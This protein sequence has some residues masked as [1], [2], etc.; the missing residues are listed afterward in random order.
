LVQVNV[1][2]ASVVV[3]L[4]LGWRKQIE[5][6]ASTLP[7]HLRIR[8]SSILTWQVAIGLLGLAVLLVVPVVALV[9]SPANP[10]I[11]PEFGEIGSWLALISAIGA[12]AWFLR[13]FAP[14]RLVHLLGCFGLGVGILAACYVSP[15]DYQESWLTYHVLTAS[16]VLCG[17]A[18]V[19][20]GC[21]W[22]VNGDQGS[23]IEG[24]NANVLP[25]S[26]LHPRSS[27]IIFW[28][29]FICL[30]VLGLGLG[31]AIGDPTKLYWSSGPVLAVSLLLG[32][33]A[34]WQRRPMHVYASGLLI[35]IVGSLIWLAGENHPWEHLAY[36]NI[37]SF[38][39]AGG[40]W[41]ALELWLVTRKRVS[42][43]GASGNEPGALA[44]GGLPFSHLA[45]MLGL[46]LCAAM[47]VLAFSTAGLDLP[48]LQV[49]SL[50]WVALA[51]IAVATVVLCWDATADFTRL[52]LYALG[53]SAI[54]L[55]LHGTQQSAVNTWWSLAI[56][57]APYV[58]LAAVLARWLPGWERVR[59]TLRLPKLPAAWPESWF[60]P[61]QFFVGAIVIALTLWMSVSFDSAGARLAGPLA[62]IILVPAGTLMAE[63]QKQSISSLPGFRSSTLE[64]VTLA[65]G[66][67]AAIEFGWGLLSPTN[68]ELS[69]LWLHRNLVLMVALSAM[70]VIYGVGLSK[71]FPLSPNPVPRGTPPEGRGELAGWS[72]CGRRMGPWLGLLACI[73]LGV[74]L[75]QETIFYDGYVAITRLVG[76]ML[77]V[78]G[79]ADMKPA[80]PDEPMA[81]EAI[82]TVACAIVALIAA[83]L[84][85]AVQP[86][87]DPLGLSERGRTAY[88]YAAEVLLVVLFVHFK[89]TMPG[90]FR[91]GWFIE[92]WPFVLMT[93]A[94]LG[95]GLSEY[96]RRKELRVLA[97]PFQW[98]GGF[99]P[100]L[101]VLTYWVLPD[102]SEYAF[103]WFF[104]GLLYGV[105]SIFKRSWRFALL[106]SVA[107]NMG[108]WVL[109][110]D[111]GFYFGKHP[112]MWLIP[113]ALVVLVA[114]QINQDRLTQNQ[115]AAIRYLALIVIY[116]SSTAD[117]FI[118]GLDGPWIWPLALMVLSVLG[119]LSGMLL[120]VRAFLYLGCSFLTLVIV[121]MIWHAGV[122]Q[123][124]TWILWSSG[125]VL[126]FAIYALFMYFEK[127]RQNVLHLVEKLKKWD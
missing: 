4:W 115:S 17:F 109:L 55:A 96:F 104:A 21:L 92:H 18:M 26:I 103:V 58:L 49:G 117:M 85:F 77:R 125:I 83:G 33:V 47:S 112:Q 53:L 99:L 19:I 62:V 127:R 3:F 118:A 2:A 120:R 16:W 89:M 22:S 98:T 40:M 97:E 45:I 50:A 13:E 20:F 31:S 102:A 25:S 107:A 76:L 14:L 52:G 23:K 126:G 59:G 44:T 42:E 78:E 110:Q 105:M 86:G 12:A 80:F 6:E 35:N 54:L 124:H 114:E 24:G 34:V 9:L 113:L 39:V 64:F 36:A 123:R 30:L 100:M 106:G 65:A 48:A 116:V 67:V 11:P 73:V 121:T 41:S 63:Q 61:A 81:M 82:I 15:W 60:V 43:L 93:I 46:I 5:P 72:A 74:V 51:A 28:L 69:W 108:L 27:V 95:V 119:V 8:F 56:S 88:V 111:S 84:C 38:A 70:T 32:A 7:A 71:A 87:R 79:A 66:T 57:A 90:L 75:V 68:H 1:V 122:N 101:P 91:R 37:L 29:Q 94:Y 10:P